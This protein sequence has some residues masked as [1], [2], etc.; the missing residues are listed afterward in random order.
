MKTSLTTLSALVLALLAN[1]VLA[2]SCAAR[3]SIDSALDEAAFVVLADAVSIEQHPAF[4]DSKSTTVTEHVTFRVI[5]TLK[6]SQRPGDLVYVRSTIGI[7]ACGVSARNS[8]VWL[9]ELKDGKT[10]AP[11][12]SG[13]WLIY[14]R[15]NEG[16]EA[17]AI[18]LSLC[19]RSSPIEA[20]GEGDLQRLRRLLRHTKSQR[21]HS[22]NAH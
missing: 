1:N 3:P 21:S 11:K 22:R 14:A 6:G 20:G 9:E 13:R 8:P 10:V 7:G 18:E 19:G 5:E 4:S 17:T 12:L 15:A 16:S 2:C